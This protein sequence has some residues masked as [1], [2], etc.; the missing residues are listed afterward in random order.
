LLKNVYMP[1]GLLELQEVLAMLPLSSV[2][3][4]MLTKGG[5]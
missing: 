5:T 3:R 2:S 4:S 1:D